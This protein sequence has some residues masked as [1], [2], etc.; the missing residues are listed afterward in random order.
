[1]DKQHTFPL[2]V[3]YLIMLN[4]K[5]HAKD[6]IILLTLNWYKDD[7]FQGKIRAQHEDIV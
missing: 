4:I 6:E 1:M 7:G 3:T 5:P 2:E